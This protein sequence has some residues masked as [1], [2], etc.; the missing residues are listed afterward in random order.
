MSSVKDK[1][2]ELVQNANK[3]LG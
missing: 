3:I 2:D 1:A